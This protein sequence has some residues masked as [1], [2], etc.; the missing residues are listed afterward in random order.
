VLAVTENHTTVI[1]KED[2]VIDGE[3]YP[4]SV[5]LDTIREAG[6]TVHRDA[7][8]RASD[9]YLKVATRNTPSGHRHWTKAEIDLLV[10]ALRLRHEAGL[11]WPR[12]VEFLESGQPLH[13]LLQDELERVQA[14]E[15][16]IRERRAALARLT[17]E[18][19]ERQAA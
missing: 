16:A 2:P 7:V 14:E 10:V 19:A 4:M 12:I 3:Q 13:L 11:L 9:R 8:I 6:L 1:T 17:D 15:D 5:V 18:I